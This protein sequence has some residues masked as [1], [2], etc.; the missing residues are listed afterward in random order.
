M[1]TEHG[2]DLYLNYDGIAVNESQPNSYHQF[3]AFNSKFSGVSGSIGATYQFSEKVFTKLNLSRGYRAPSIGEAGANGVHDGTSRYEIGD[4]NLKAE[5][6]L[7]LDYAIGLNS[8]HITAEVDVFSNNI[9]NFIF[10]SK[11]ESVSGGDSLNQ[12]YSTF[13]FVS[14]NANLF[15]GEF[16]IDIH[17]HPLDWLHF[18]N[19]FSFVQSIQKGQPDSSRYLPLTPAP[20][21]TSELRASSKKLGRYLANAYI[22]I[23]LDNYFAQ[24]KFYSAYGTE[25]ATPGYTLLNFGLGTDIT[26]K[27]K[28]IFSLYISADNITDVAYQSHLSRLK[29]GDVNTVTGRTGVF[30]M[31]RNISFKLI[32]PIDFSKK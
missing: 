29:Y 9:N 28:T 24:N 8:K 6:S 32:V 19:S 10:S 27:H 3:T 25:T 15:G 18:E 23:G 13:K 22:K 17:P 12:G 5:N 7:Q 11:L 14:G 21:F 1:R 26:T 2:K 16:S 30:N 20:K 4:P 31:G